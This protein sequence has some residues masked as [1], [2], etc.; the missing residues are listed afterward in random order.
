M[1]QKSRQKATWCVERNF[2]K[3]LH[4]RNFGINW[5]NKT[6]SYEYYDKR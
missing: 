2:L 5:E 3:L 6:L 4:N 1:N